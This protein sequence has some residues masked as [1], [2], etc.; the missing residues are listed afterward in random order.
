MAEQLTHLWV[1]IDAGKAH[2]WLTG[3]DETGATI[4]FSRSIS[5]PRGRE[6]VDGLC[7]RP[8]PD[9]A[10]SHGEPVVHLPGADTVSAAGQTRKHPLITL[11]SQA[12]VLASTLR[13]WSTSSFRRPW[14]LCNSACISLD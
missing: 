11:A 14:S 4:W 6:F 1:G 10:G 9:R 12:E 8:V 7:A 2:H 13:S 3:V 5:R